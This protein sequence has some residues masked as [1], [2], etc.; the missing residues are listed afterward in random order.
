MVSFCACILN[1]LSLFPLITY[2]N[3]FNHH[4]DIYKLAPWFNGRRRL[5]VFQPDGWT[6]RERE[7]WSFRFNLSCTLLQEKENGL[8]IKLEDAMS[9]SC[10]FNKTDIVYV[11]WGWKFVVWSWAASS[12]VA[13]SQ[14]GRLTD[15]LFMRTVGLKVTLYTAMTICTGVKGFIQGF[16]YFPCLKRSVQYWEGLLHTHNREFRYRNE[17]QNFTRNVFKC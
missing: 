2:I 6:Q 15:K 17:D 13:G 11:Y 9:P 5:S 3:H 12:L 14:P 4:F 10:W 16:I 1:F 7:E 8:W